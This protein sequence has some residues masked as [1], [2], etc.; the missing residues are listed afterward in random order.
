M[1]NE[2]IYSIGEAIMLEVEAVKNITYPKG[3]E[4]PDILYIE[5]EDGKRFELSLKAIR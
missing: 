2:L 3:E 4:E 1:E 5:L